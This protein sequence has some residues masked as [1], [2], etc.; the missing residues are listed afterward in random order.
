MKVAV[1]F[2][3]CFAGVL[4]AMMA[5]SS[6]AGPKP[7]E[8]AAKIAPD[9]LAETA[10]GGS[11]SIVILLA[12]QADVSAAHEMK[13]PDARG[14]FVYNT[15]TQHA[16]QTQ[17][18]LRAELEAR[19]V[20]YQSFWAANMIV[21]T[22]DRAPIDRSQ[23]ARCGAMDSNKRGG[24]S[25]KWRTECAGG[26]KRRVGCDQRNA[27]TAGRWDLPGRM[28]RQDTGQRWTHNAFSRGI[29]AGTELPPI[30]ITTGATRST[31]AVPAAT[32]PFA[33]TTTGPTPPAPRSG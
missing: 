21:A 29:V 26:P 11:A 33:T 3:L 31:R 27:P 9:V 32:L 12:D 20:S 6:A 15:L 18:G 25:R 28:V 17:A 2:A 22:A 16:T 14:W 10:E 8:I 13:D 23:S 24:S 5:W 1:S 7:A 30:T 4:L 19:G